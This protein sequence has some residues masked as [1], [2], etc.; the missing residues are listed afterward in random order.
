MTRLP[1]STGERLLTFVSSN[2]YVSQYRDGDTAH[3]DVRTTSRGEQDACKSDRG[4]PYWRLPHW[5][6]GQ[7]LQERPTGHRHLRRRRAAQTVTQVAAG[8][9]TPTS[10]A[11]GAGKV[12]EGDGGSETSKVP[13]GGV[14]LLSGGKGVKLAGSPNFVS[15]LAWHK[16]AL[17]VAGGTLTNKGPV[18]QIQRWSGFNGTTFA[19]RTVIWTA[20]R[21][22]TAPTGSRSRPTVACSSA[23]TSD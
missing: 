10:F 15:G 19:K 16:S 21:A 22:S 14:Y 8:L 7:R 13:N 17:Y 2:G 6:P 4:S 12:F 23:S 20:P 11:V 1:T 18:W 3:T 9:Q 5:G